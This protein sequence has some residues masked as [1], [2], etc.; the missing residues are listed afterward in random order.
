MKHP[1]ILKQMTL[2]EKT[3]ILSGKTV[4]DTMGIER[5]SLPSLCCSDGPHGVRKQAGAADHLGLNASVPA[6][7]FPTAATVANSWDEALAELIGMALGEEAQ[8]QGVDILLGPGLNIKRSPLCGRNFEYFSEDP[9]LSGKMAA[10]YIRGIQKKSTSAC[11][12]HF[13]V[14]S[15]ELRRMAMNAVV[16][17]RTLREIYLTGFEIA[18]KEGKPDTIMTSYNEVNGIYANENEHL[19]KE[20]LRGEWGFD[21]IVVTDWGGSNDHVKGVKAGSNLE[22]P[23][24]GY[25]SARTLIKALET[26]DLTE[27]ELDECVD[28]LVD[29]M[30]KVSVRKRKAA[31]EM[32][33]DR[34]DQSHQSG[35]AQH[36]DQSHRSDRTQHEDQAHRSDRTQ[37]TNQ[38]H[39]K[40]AKKAAVRSAVLLKNEDE[41]LPLSAGTR[42]AVIGDFAFHP[43]Y[44]GAGS[45]AVNAKQVDC[46]AELLQNYELT[47]NGVGRGYRRDGEA[48]EKLIEEGVNIA[49]GADAVLFFFGLNEI[50]ESEGMDRSSLAIPE[51]Q[52]EVLR[53]LAKV[54]SNIIGIL[55]AGSVVETEWEKY[56]QG[57][58]HGY[59]NGEAGAGAILDLVTGKETPSGKLAESYPMTLEQNPSYG[60]FGGKERN[61]EYRESIYVGYRYYDKAEAQGK[62]LVRYP[63]GYG[64]S[65]TA[66]AYSDLKVTDKG[67]SFWLANT[68]AWRGAEIAQ[69]YVSLPESGIFRAEK[70]LK[71]FCRVELEPGESKQAEIVFDDKTF[72][73]W[74]RQTNT[75]EVEG[76]A[77]QI[78][79]GANS[80]D[81]RLSGEWCLEGTTRVQPYQKEEFPA[82]YSGEIAKITDD[83][84]RKLLGNEK[85]YVQRSDELTVNDAI[86]QMQ[87]AKSAL[88]RGVYRILEVKQKKSLKSGKPDLNISFICN[89]PFRGIAKMTN[90]MVS[91]EIAEGMVRIVNGSF[92]SGLGRIIVGWFHNRKENARFAKRLADAEAEQESHGAQQKSG[93][94]AEQ[95]SGR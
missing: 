6:T 37:H 90:G 71:G 94:D 72:R 92:W 31:L 82:Y 15:Q 14:N 9:Y 78:L 24:P 11:P 67:V 85:A 39:H 20:I 13:A 26:G 12:K 95:Q 93:C 10:A 44:Q 75:W 59:L 79:I 56:C 76:G 73:Y 80:R 27:K 25:D 35:R 65:Y 77:Y 47:V 33:A 23:N 30:Q 34:A 55:S 32:P 8:E 18:V 38:A 69:L 29:L 83:Q 53:A 16:D 49:A 62:K 43:R 4:F 1:E 22:M 19:L 21:G 68:G 7:C 86:S 42:V 28:P 2:E 57:L 48:D 70:E 91:M 84:F 51:N 17:E 74:N 87:H 81:I 61:V 89:M 41:I 5:L 54:N 40:L 58:L 3:A 45:S 60:N 88:A 36:A 52:K 46:A 64:L 63:F 50:S 66:F